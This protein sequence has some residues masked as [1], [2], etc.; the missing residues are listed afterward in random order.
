MIVAVG[1][2]QGVHEQ[3]DDDDADDHGA[4]PKISPDLVALFREVLAVSNPGGRPPLS[5]SLRL[6]PRAVRGAASG[7]LVPAGVGAGAGAPGAG[8]AGAPFSSRSSIWPTRRV[9]PGFRTLSVIF[10]PV[11]KVPLVEFKSF[12]T[13][14]WPR[15]STSQ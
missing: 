10:S 13:T 12:T 7:F 8:G 15:S 3:N 4:N 5:N 14:S 2:R 9:W 11:M 1:Q 6:T